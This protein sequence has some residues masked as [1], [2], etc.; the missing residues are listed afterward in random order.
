MF[1]KKNATPDDLRIAGFGI[2]SQPPERGNDGHRHSGRDAGP[3]RAR[4]ESSVMDGNAEAGNKFRYKELSSIHIP[5]LWIP[6][7]PTGMTCFERLVYKDECRSVGT[8]PL[9][10]RSFT[11]RECRTLYCHLR[12]NLAPPLSLS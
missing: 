8:M 3:V 1:S 7:I 4:S 6:A 12:K 9:T 2:L 11:S 10:S 5:V